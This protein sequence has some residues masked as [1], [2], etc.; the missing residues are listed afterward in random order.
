MLAP[1]PNAC[2]HRQPQASAA[3]LQSNRFLK[4]QWR[5]A[6]GSQ[7]WGTSHSDPAALSLLGGDLQEPPLHTKQ[8]PYQPTDTLWLL[9]LFVQCNKI[10]PEQGLRGAQSPKALPSSHGWWW[11]DNSAPLPSPSAGSL[12]ACDKG[13]KQ[14][15]TNKQFELMGRQLFLA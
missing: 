10:F 12:P 9:L 1:F 8:K 4:N 6:G 7:G 2:S 5:Q 11:G 3:A 13:R 15:K 14:L